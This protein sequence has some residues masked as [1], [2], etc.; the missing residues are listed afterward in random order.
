[1]NVFHMPLFLFF[2]ITYN[3]TL[4]FSP[5]PVNL[6]RYRS[7]HKLLVMKDGSTASGYFNVG[8][9]IC[10]DADVF[11][12]SADGKKFSSKGLVGTVVEIWEKCEVDP[13]CCCAEL[14]H[15]APFKVEF[16]GEK[17]LALL[18]NSSWCAQFASE[19]LRLVSNR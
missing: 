17:I 3:F 19:E 2:A 4:S 1:M 16:K 9:I 11:H 14:A 12:L 13:H 5:G 7:T 15:D 18:G 8:D 10:V 6:V